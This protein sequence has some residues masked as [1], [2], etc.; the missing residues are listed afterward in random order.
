MRSR[1][2]SAGARGFSL[3]EVLV[4][5]IVVSV[6]L[7][8]IAKMQAIAYSSTGVASKRSLA[9]IE[10]ASL[11]S[12]MHANRAYWSV[13][14][15]APASTTVTGNAVTASTDPALLAAVDC[16]SG[17]AVPC[18]A[19]ALA[20]YDLGFGPTSWA[21]ALQSLLGTSDQAVI[22]CVNPAPPQTPVTCTVTITWSENQ[23]ALNSQEAAA[24]NAAAAA[25]TPAALQLPSYTLYIEP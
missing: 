4:A 7:L 17:G 24:A 2:T 8:G 13:S 14:G 11:A 12:S 25:N 5:L 16:T 3:I 15:I 22:A 20:A 6:G 19:S 1:P 23:V 9:A 21:A 18:T 10:A